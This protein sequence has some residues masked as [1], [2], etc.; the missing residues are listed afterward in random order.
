MVARPEGR[1]YENISVQARAL[2]IGLW[3]SGQGCVSIQ[4]LQEFFVSVTAKISRPLSVEDATDEVANLSAWHL[5]QPAAGDVMA[6]IELH[7]RHRIS[8]WDAMILQSARR[9]GC[10]V[11]WTEDL[12]DGQTY[13]GVTVKNPFRGEP[14]RDGA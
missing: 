10:E 14:R 13:D 5:H 8:F 9:M 2:V 11:L 4:V 12:N 7:G 3:Q 1:A 6:A